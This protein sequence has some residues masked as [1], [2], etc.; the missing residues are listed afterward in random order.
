VL[1]ITTRVTRPCTGIWLPAAF[2]AGA[3]PLSL[4]AR[5]NWRWRTQFRV[6]SSQSVP[7]AVNITQPMTALTTTICNL[8]RT[9]RCC[10]YTCDNEHYTRHCRLRTVG[11]GPSTVL[12]PWGPIGLKAFQNVMRHESS[13]QSAQ[14]SA[15]GTYS[16][17]RV[18]CIGSPFPHNT[19][20]YQF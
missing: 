10:I 8:K 12:A 2:C 16:Y 9:W 13:L 3:G 4:L 7:Q 17:Y 6:E 11:A 18:R 5:Y 15:T 14:N 20:Q 1:L 19:A